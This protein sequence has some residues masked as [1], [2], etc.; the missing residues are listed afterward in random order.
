M[1]CGLSWETRHLRYKLG[2]LAKNFLSN[3]DNSAVSVMRIRNVIQICVRSRYCTD[4]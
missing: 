1:R 4:H 2:S 3:T